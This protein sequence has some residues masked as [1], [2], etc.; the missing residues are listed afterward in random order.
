MGA[1]H[2]LMVPGA[3]T[4]HVTGE[5]VYPFLLKQFNKSITCINSSF[6]TTQD[7]LIALRIRRAFVTALLKYDSAR[8]EVGWDDLEE[9]FA[10]VVDL[11]AS[12]LE[13]DEYAMRIYYNPA[14]QKHS[15]D[16]ARESSHPTSFPFSLAAG[17]SELLYF[18]AVHC[19]RPSVR[20]RAVHLLTAYPRREGI[21]ESML[22]GSVAEAAGVLEDSICDKGRDSSSECARRAGR[23]VCADHR[24]LQ[25]EVV[26][27]CE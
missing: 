19:R 23:Y 14:A 16:L 12:I 13:S 18:V 15:L 22:V 8:D 9:S 27:V 6:P 4:L 26:Y 21:R 10:T 7:A 25:V 1:I 20:L 24:I 3:G 11:T 17:V 5:E 2:R